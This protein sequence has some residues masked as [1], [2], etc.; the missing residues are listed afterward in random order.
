MAPTGRLRTLF[1]AHVSHAQTRVGRVLVVVLA[2]AGLQVL[3]Q[4]LLARTL[5]KTEVGLVSLL[6]GALPIL[7]TFSLLG[8]EASTVRFLTRSGGSS[9]DTASHVRKVLTLV[10]PLGAVAGLAGAWFYGLGW[11]LAFT[12]VAL[13]LSQNTV[14]VAT[15]VLR[16]AHRYELAMTGT[17]LPA[18]AAAAALLALKVSGTLTLDTAVVA[19]GLSFVAAA[20]IFTTR[21]WVRSE[22]DAAPVPRS[23]MGEGLLF[24]GLGISFAVMVAIDKLIIGKM[25]TYADLAVYASIFAIMRGFDFLFYSINYV[26]MPRVNLVERLNLRRIHLAIAAVAVV[27]AG[28]YLLLGDD[29]I[30]LLYAGRYDEGT[31]LILPF[32]LSGIAKLFYSVPSSV[33]GGRLPRRALKHFMW[34]NLA[35]MGVNIVLDIAFIRAMGLTGAALATAIAWTLRLLGG[36]VIIALNRSHLGPHPAEP[37]QV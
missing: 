17:R 6:L 19:L 22:A 25:M 4:T 16:A 21:S 28:L 7:S 23:V 18:M 35:G 8:Q 5:T 11:G 13:V 20:F 34:L 33:I 15:S 27:V 30:S 3:T 9:Y 37:A 1:D 12:L 2:S 31:H 14:S 26:L 32:A 24:L 29:I 10:L 36:Y